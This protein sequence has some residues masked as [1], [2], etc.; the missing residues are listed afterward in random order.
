M[1][2]LAVFNSCLKAY[3]TGN[4]DVEDRKKHSPGTLKKELAFQLLMLVSSDS[5]SFVSFKGILSF[6]ETSP[7]GMSSS[8]YPMYRD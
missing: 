5:S 7:K 6:R 2:S 1:S 3:L 8:G 4:L